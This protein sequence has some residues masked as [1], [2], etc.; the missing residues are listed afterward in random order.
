M[1]GAVGL[2]P[3]TDGVRVRCLTNL[4]T[5]QLESKWWR[6]KDSN[7]RRQCQQIYSLPPLA[8]SGIP[9]CYGADNRIRTYDLL[10]TSQLLYQLSYVGI[11]KKMAEPT[12]V[13]LAISCVTGRHVRPL[14]HGSA[15]SN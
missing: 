1:A 12:R 8:N 15:K 11:V 2:E 13:E 5:P 9:P 10:I 7:L 6:E 4:A 3:T 14:H